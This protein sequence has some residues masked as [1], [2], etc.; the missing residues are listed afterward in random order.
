M[1]DFYN[2]HLSAVESYNTGFVGDQFSTDLRE[3]GPVFAETDWHGSREAIWR[4]VPHEQDIY[5]DNQ[6][7]FV[8][9]TDRGINDRLPSFCS[10]VTILNSDRSQDDADSIP[11]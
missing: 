8:A 4:H 2:R 10:T 6:P 3:P 1:R 11:I 7:R 5:G 9:I